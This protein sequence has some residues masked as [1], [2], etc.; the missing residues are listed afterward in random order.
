MWWTTTNTEVSGNH[1]GD[2]DAS[3]QK[4]LCCQ[5]HYLKWQDDGLSAMVTEGVCEKDDEVYRDIANISLEFGRR[6]YDD[7]HSLG[8]IGCGPGVD[9]EELGKETDG[10]L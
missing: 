2:Y 6:I 8:V 4:P 3:Y 9:P 1:Q 7:T 10:I 5:Q